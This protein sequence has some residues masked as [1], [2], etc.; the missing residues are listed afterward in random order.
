MAILLKPVTGE[1]V[2]VIGFPVP[3]GEG[4]ETAWAGTDVGQLPFPGKNWATYFR[5]EVQD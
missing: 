2:I 1:Q 3:C 4:C 5:Y